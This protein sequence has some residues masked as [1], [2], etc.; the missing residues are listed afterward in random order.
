MKV[1]DGA[2]VDVQLIAFVTDLWHIS[3][4][5]GFSMNKAKKKKMHLNT[6]IAMYKNVCKADS[7]DFLTVTRQNCQ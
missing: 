3:P 5:S 2:Y 1:K 6:A 7:V 4:F